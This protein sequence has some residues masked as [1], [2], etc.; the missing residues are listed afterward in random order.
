MSAT[1]EQCGGT[2]YLVS[3]RDGFTGARRCLCS[4]QKDAVSRIPNSGLPADLRTRTFE[5]FQLPDRVSNPTHHGHLEPVYREVKRYAQEWLPH[6]LGSRKPG[7][8]IIGDHGIGK[9]HLAVAAFLKIL[10]RG[11]DGTYFDYQML[12]DQ[13]Q[14]AWNPTAGTS[15][16]E[17]YRTALDTPV[18]LL[19]DIGARRSIEWVEDTITA[20]I[21]HRCNHKL[22]LISTTNLPLESEISTTRTAG[23]GPRYSRTLP[24]L[25]GA[26]AASRLYE[27]C[28]IVRMPPIPDYRQSIRD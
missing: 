7:L 12:L 25:I 16:R 24:E 1:C 18:L 15:E 4:R 27:M 28:R 6:P 20:I 26:R 11:F 22:A 14:A 3:E 13:V 9:T 8:L 23:G 19:D 21:T 2:G 5:N 17:A 10:E